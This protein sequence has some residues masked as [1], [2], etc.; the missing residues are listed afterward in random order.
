MTDSNISDLRARYVREIAQ[1]EARL[2]E[3]DAQLEAGYEKERNA[4]AALIVGE[5]SEAAVSEALWE[6]ENF[7]EGRRI[8]QS[9]IEGLK[10]RLGEAERQA[11]RDD[12]ARRLEAE[13]TPA[14]TELVGALQRLEAACGQYGEALNDVV[15]LNNRACAAWPNQLRGFEQSPQVIGKSA[16]G[17]A[18]QAYLEMVGHLHAM[19]CAASNEAWPYRATPPLNAIAQTGAQVLFNLDPFVKR[20]SGQWLGLLGGVAERPD[21]AEIVRATIDGDHGSREAEAA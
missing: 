4:R 20:F 14:A 6:I 9:E 2:P 5:G 19:L 8:V 12:I 13:V 3:I 15:K 16:G 21:L 18:S 1:R 10:A 17:F 7:K 11:E